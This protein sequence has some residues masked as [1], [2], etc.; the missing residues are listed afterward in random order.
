MP[1]KRSKLISFDA[2]PG[3]YIRRLQQISVAIFLQETEGFGITPVQFAALSA[4][5]EFP[6]IDQK[7]LANTIG[8]DTSTI[9][10]VIDRLE[11][12]GFVLRNPSNKDRRVHVLTL[13]SEGKNLLEKINPHVLQAQDRILSP[14]KKSQH[15]ELIQ[16][17]DILVNGN[18]DAS[19]APSFMKPLEN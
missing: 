6:Q 3:H 17:L 10:G 2:L 5:E 7:T 16:M 9:G 18:N 19:R 11:S 8:L 13:T 1:N 14:L 4:L 12:R 15:G